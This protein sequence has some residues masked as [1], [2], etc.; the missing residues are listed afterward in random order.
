MS[1]ADTEATS[2]VYHK[3]IHAKDIQ[4]GM[5]IYQL[6]RPWIETPFMFQCFEVQTEEQVL[7]LKQQDLY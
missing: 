5:Y 6:D 3:K 1:Q 4:Q 7:E 2:S